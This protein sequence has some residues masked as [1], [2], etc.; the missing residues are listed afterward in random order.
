MSSSLV[1]MTFPTFAILTDKRRPCTSPS[2]PF[3][4][5]FDMFFIFFFFRDVVLRYIEVQLLLISPICPHIAETLWTQ[6]GKARRPLFFWLSVYLFIFSLGSL[7]SLSM[8][9]GLQPRQLT[10]CSP[11]RP[12]MVKPPRLCEP[13]SEY[14][15]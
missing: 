11:V 13:S 6:I 15:S 8:R 9:V 7:V 14:V 2:I 5:L 3:F 4:G 12:P 1:S 10:R